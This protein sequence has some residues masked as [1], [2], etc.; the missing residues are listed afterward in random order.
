MKIPEAPK[1]EIDKAP[2]RKSASYQTGFNANRQ[3]VNT[4]QNKANYLRES[5]MAPA[6]S[7]KDGQRAVNDMYKGMQGNTVAQMN[8]QNA[9][10]NAQQ[11]ANDMATRS[12]LTQQGLANQAQIYQDMNKRAIDQIGLASQLNEAMIRSKFA[13]LSQQAMKAK[14][15]LN[16]TPGSGWVENTLGGL[17]K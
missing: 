2:S 10:M 15:A 7:S 13:V 8:R 11:S 5:L 16:S 4:G 9:A 6:V 12:Q 3:A 17:L 14:S 1:I